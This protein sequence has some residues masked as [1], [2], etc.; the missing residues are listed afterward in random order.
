MI[1]FNKTLKEKGDNAKEILKLINYFIVEKKILS[2]ENIIIEFK[3]V[4]NDLLSSFVNISFDNYFDTFVE[5]I[6]NLQYND[7]IYSQNFYTNEIQRLYSYCLTKQDN[8]TIRENQIKLFK[9]IFG[10]LEINDAYALNRIQLLLGYPEMIFK[11]EK[12]SNI[13]LFGVNIMNDDINTEIFEYIGF[14]HIKKYRSVLSFLF[15]SSNEKN[16]ENYLEEKDRNDLIYELIK[17]CFGLNEKK[18]GN[19]YLFKTLYLMQSRAIKYD[20]LYQE[21]KETLEKANNNKY[22]LEKFKHI[23]KECINLINNNEMENMKMSNISV[24]KENKCKIPECFK[25]YDI[26]TKDVKE[27]ICDIIP[28]ETGKIYIRLVLSKK[29]VKI[30]SFEYFTTYFTKKEL[31]GLAKDNCKFI[32]K[33]VKR[34]KSESSEE[35][36]IKNDKD[37]IKDISAFKNEKDLFSFINSNITEEKGIIL[38]NGDVSKK[39][40]KNTIVRYYVYSQSQN[41]LVKLECKKEYFK[42]ENN[43][44][45][46]LPEIMRDL[47][48]TEDNE[49]KNII[50]IYRIK[51]DLD[52]LKPDSLLN[53]LKCVKADKYLASIGL[54]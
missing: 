17:M 37:L 28:Y 53:Y 7:Q 48:S 49:I 36:E 9:L 41:L 52:F 23:E 1:L 10:L 54:K 46:Y 16:V 14:N 26:N 45:F 33:N 47:I 13:S 42:E 20:N 30:F 6:K 4:S 11:Q 50:N 2:K 39:S 31:K 19:Y 27:T 32:Y 18:Q 43:F 24:N 8:G 21:M 40:L 44:N 29:T 22:D 35:K 51:N 3:K 25:T 38:E 15:P 34:F 12:K 5:L